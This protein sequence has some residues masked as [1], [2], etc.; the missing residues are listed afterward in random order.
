M[1]AQH[2][3]LGKSGEHS[4]S[5][6]AAR[7]PAR[8]PPCGGTTVS[9]ADSDEVELRLRAA[10]LSA[11]RSDWR[12]NVSAADS[13]SLVARPSLQ[14]LSPR[15]SDMA[16]HWQPARAAPRL[17]ARRAALAACSAR[18]LPR[19][20]VHRGVASRVLRGAPLAACAAATAAKDPTPT[21]ARWRAGGRCCGII[22]CATEREGA[23]SSLA[24]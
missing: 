19:N 24:A 13:D 10:Q 20:P 4:V 7:M 9:T 18:S 15:R 21:W 1:A 17:A 12:F 16:H 14:C 6:T 11:P 23:P 5:A 3:S 2:I 8:M 22:E